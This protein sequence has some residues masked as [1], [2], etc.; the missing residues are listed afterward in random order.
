MQVSLFCFWLE[1]GKNLKCPCHWLWRMLL[2]QSTFTSS[3]WRGSQLCTAQEEWERTRILFF[4]CWPV[5]NVQKWTAKTVWDNDLYMRYISTCIVSLWIWAW[6]SSSLI[7]PYSDALILAH[8]YTFGSKPKF[9]SLGRRPGWLAIG[10]RTCSLHI[11]QGPAVFFFS[12][13]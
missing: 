8:S 4:I 10:M 13:Q 6:A 3:N 2:V 7:I 12:P 11:L 9:T 5:A 1:R